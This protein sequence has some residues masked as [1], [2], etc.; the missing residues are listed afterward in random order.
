M[1]KTVAALLA[2][3]FLLAAGT[4]AGE[5][6]Q[7]GFDAEAFIREF[8]ALWPY[9]QKFSWTV[10]AEDEREYWNGSYFY[11]QGIG[12]PFLLFGIGSSISKNP[13]IMI[14]VGLFSDTYMLAGGKE[15]CVMRLRFLWPCFVLM[16]LD[17]MQKSLTT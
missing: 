17:M 5:G 16:N 12:D 9:E 6:A 3:W 14:S 2:V 7:G 10:V 8:E 1:R 13:S 11:L 15:Y 4:A